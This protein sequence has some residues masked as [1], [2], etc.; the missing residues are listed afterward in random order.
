MDF[1]VGDRVILGFYNLKNAVDVEDGGHEKKPWSLYKKGFIAAIIGVICTV[2]LLFA[3]GVTEQNA[4]VMGVVLFFSVFLA[5]S[6][7]HFLKSR[8]E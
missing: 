7:S 6:I 2:L 1:A 3:P 8:Q 4:L 5:F